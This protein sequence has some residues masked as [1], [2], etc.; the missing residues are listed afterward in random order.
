MR[1]SL[2][3]HPLPW[4]SHLYTLRIKLLS[5]NSRPA[6]LTTHVKMT[7]YYINIGQQKDPSLASLCLPFPYLPVLSQGK[8][9]YYDIL[10]P[11]SGSLIH[12]ACLIASSLSSHLG[13]FYYKSLQ[14]PLSVLLPA[15]R[16]CKLWRHLT[17]AIGGTVARASGFSALFTNN[18]RLLI[19][20]EYEEKVKITP[21]LP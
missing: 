3:K 10:I 7:P 1:F 13:A 16:W 8:K 20:K 12:P 18:D 4:D 19:F 9:K 2:W 15:S 21:A 11:L 6:I 17:S 14:K 5:S